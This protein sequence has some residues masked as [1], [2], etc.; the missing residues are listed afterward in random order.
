MLNNIEN[1]PFTP[2]TPVPVDM[3]VGR[4]EQIEKILSYVNRAKRG[5]QENI[6]LVGERGIGKSSLASFLRYRISDDILGVHIFLGR[7]SSLD[8]MV[9]RIFDGVL[10][11]SRNRSWFDN[12]RDLFGNYIQ[13]VSIFGVSVSFAPPEEDL[14]E[15]VRNFPYAMANL[16][17]KLKNK[18]K[19]LFIVL[20]DIN[21]I[22]EKPEFA[23]W[24]KSFVDEVATHYK[25]FPVLIMLVGVP[26]RRVVLSNMQ[27]SLMRIFRVI[28]IEKLSDEEVKTFFD[29]AFGTVGVRVKRDAMNMMVKYSSGLPLIMQEI[30][31]ETLRVDRDDSIDLSDARIGIANAAETVGRKYLDPKVYKAIRSETYLAILRKIGYHFPFR[32]FKKSDIAKKLDERERKVFNNFL[33]RMRQLGVIERD[34]EKGR[35][36]YKFVNE[37]Y[38]IYIFMESIRYRERTK[39]H[40]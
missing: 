1:S 9:R 4:S 27:P 12:I 5:N 11:E 36:S 18:K 32:T 37:L 39:K 26:E 34:V 25:N 8:E 6:F 15:L 20:D 17:E 24:Y 29:G 31:D 22:A 3:F 40:K 19:A 23:N 28:E 38:P 35:G 10:K 30:G 13:E 33:N 16:I 21:G 7:V 14:N 2:G